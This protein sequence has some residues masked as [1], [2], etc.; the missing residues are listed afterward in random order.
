[1]NPLG[2]DEFDYVGMFGSTAEFR[3]RAECV[4]LSVDT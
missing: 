4:L 1:M 2:S 3:T